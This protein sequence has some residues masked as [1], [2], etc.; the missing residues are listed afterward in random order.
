MKGGGILKRNR[1]P[2]G[3]ENVENYFMGGWKREVE[4]GGGAC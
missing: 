4:G 1:D 3:P 2:T